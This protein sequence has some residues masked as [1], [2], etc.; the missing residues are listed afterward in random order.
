M[1][2]ILCHRPITYIIIGFVEPKD[3]EEPHPYMSSSPNLGLQSSSSKFQY[4][5]IPEQ[6]SLSFCVPVTILLKSNKPEQFVIMFRHIYL[7]DLYVYFNKSKR[8]FHVFRY[9]CLRN[10]VL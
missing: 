3:F 8:I 4:V 7:Y 10:S 1:F 5:L 2:P 9:E 6:I